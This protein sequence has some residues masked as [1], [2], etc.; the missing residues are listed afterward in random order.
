MNGK[1]SAVLRNTR[2]L[3]ASLALVLREALLSGSA[4]ADTALVFTGGELGFWKTR[5]LGILD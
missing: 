4:R 5:G 1:N 3:V 2:S